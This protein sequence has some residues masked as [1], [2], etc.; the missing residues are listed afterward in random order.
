MNFLSGKR[1]SNGWVTSPKDEDSLPKG[2]VIL[3]N[4]RGLRFSKERWRKLPLWDGLISYQLVG[5]AMA[6][7]GYDG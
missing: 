2:R 1:V 7:Q 4:V 3:N 5:E 6:Y